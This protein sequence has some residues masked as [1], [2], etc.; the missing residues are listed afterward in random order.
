MW[1]KSLL[2]VSIKK[3]IKL[4]SVQCSLVLDR[5]EGYKKNRDTLSDCVLICVN[6][7]QSSTKHVHTRKLATHVRRKKTNE[8]AIAWKF[9]QLHGTNVEQWPKS[10]WVNIIIR[11]NAYSITMRPFSSHLLQIGLFY[12]IYVTATN[13]N[14]LAFHINFELDLLL[15]NAILRIVLSYSRIRKKWQKSASYSYTFYSVMCKR[16]KKR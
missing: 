10:S 12:C 14:L 9:S 11:P 4:L 13:K 8:L 7:I 6:D 2:L 1:I 5:K 3:R 15:T 16:T